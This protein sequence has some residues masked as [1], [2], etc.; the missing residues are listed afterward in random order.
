MGVRSCD[1]RRLAL[2]LEGLAGVALLEEDGY[3]AA[4]LLEPPPARSG[5]RP[6]RPRAGRSRSA[7]AVG[8]RTGS[9]PAPSRPSAPMPPRLPLPRVPQ[10]RGRRDRERDERRDARVQR[11]LVDAETRAGHPSRCDGGHSCSARSA[12]ARTSSS[13]GNS[14]RCSRHSTSTRA[15]WRRSRADVICWRWRSRRPTAT[16]RAGDARVSRPDLTWYE[17]PADAGP[18]QRRRG[19]ASAPFRKLGY[20]FFPQRKGS[21]HES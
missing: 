17:P 20:V 15:Y 8:R 12:A 4:W 5:S 2:A 14:A 21:H 6:D 7:P 9:S 11:V 19:A 3:A 18:R 13:S 1:P 16:P 10:I